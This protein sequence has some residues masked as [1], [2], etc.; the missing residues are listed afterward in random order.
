M[1]KSK[2]LPILLIAILVLSTGFSSPF[3][4]SAAK[5][6]KSKEYTGEELFLAV[7]MGQGQLA[8]EKYKH[9]WTKDQFK[10]NNSKEAVALG[11][12]IVSE[13]KDMEPEYF[14]EL[15][16]AVYNANY[17]ETNNILT[18]GEDLFIKAL[19]NIGDD[20]V[21]TN[22]G[23]VDPNASL[24]VVFAVYAAVVFTV[25][26]AIT[27]AGAVTFYLTAAAAGPGLK[28]IDST[29]YEQEEVV[30]EIVDATLN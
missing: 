6:S 22:K 19:E 20:V 25:G 29:S 7:V 1:L 15:Q 16:T 24:A 26:A 21:V 10:T 2:F 11:Q 13:I 12:D 14:S 27:H 18:D 4:V 3:G 9:L 28:S 23:Q 30:K 8:K 17:V 5:K